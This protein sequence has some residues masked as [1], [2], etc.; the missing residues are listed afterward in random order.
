MNAMIDITCPKCQRRFGWRGSMLNRPACPQCSHRP[1][2]EELARMQLT[3]EDDL[4]ALEEKC[5]AQDER[6]GGRPQ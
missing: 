2:A 1:P 4:A 5:R 3:L 6:Y